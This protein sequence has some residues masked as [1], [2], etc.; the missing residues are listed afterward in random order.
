VQGTGCARGMRGM[1]EGY[2]M[3]KQ[4][5]CEGY[6]MGK[7][8]MESAKDGMCNGSVRDSKLIRK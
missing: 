7:Q 3:G 6:A 5:M 2:A 8:G 1:C 4:G